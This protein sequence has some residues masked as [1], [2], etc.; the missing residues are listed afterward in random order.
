MSSNSKYTTI[1]VD[2][3]ALKFLE[4]YGFTVISI[5]ETDSLTQKVKNEV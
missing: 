3:N 5:E 1:I 2:N 4:K